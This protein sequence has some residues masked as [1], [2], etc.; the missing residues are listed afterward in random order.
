MYKK[1]WAKAL[2]HLF[3]HQAEQSESLWQVKQSQLSVLVEFPAVYRT[4]CKKQNRYHP[5]RRKKG[6]ADV[7]P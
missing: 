2:L 3:R 4:L 5:A 7:L 1:E 6:I